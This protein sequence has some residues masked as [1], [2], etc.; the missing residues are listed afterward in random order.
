MAAEEIR[1]EKTAK[2]IEESKRFYNETAK[3][4]ALQPRRP[5]SRSIMKHMKSVERTNRGILLWK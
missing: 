1:R 5:W 4:A 2:Q 3:P